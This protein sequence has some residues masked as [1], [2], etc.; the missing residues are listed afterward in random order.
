MGV[1]LNK[2]TSTQDSVKGT[3]GLI[4]VARAKLCNAEREVSVG[5]KAV[6]VYLDVGRAVHRL[7]GVIPILRVGRKHRVTELVPVTRLL[8]KR[9]ITDLRRVH[10]LI[11]IILT[12]LAH[13]LN[14]SLVQGPPLRVP[15]HH[16]RRLFLGVEQVLN[17]TNLSVVSLLSLFE[18]VTV[19]R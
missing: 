13:V 10:L 2:F 16:A 14:D 8:P 6:L 1:M 15:E 3:R 5:F 11:A 18:S 7:H 17:F 4:P 19:R 12:D 9:S